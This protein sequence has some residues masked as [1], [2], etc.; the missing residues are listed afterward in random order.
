M[1]LLHRA[2]ASGETDAVQQLIATHENVNVGTVK[3]RQ[4]VFDWLMISSK[5]LKNWCP[6]NCN[7]ID[8]FCTSLNVLVPLKPFG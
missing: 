6:I 1:T 7:F 5:Y 3:V 2:A 8:A 4:L